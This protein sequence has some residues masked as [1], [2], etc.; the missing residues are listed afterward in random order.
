MTTSLIKFHKFT[1]L[2]INVLTTSQDIDNKIKRNLTNIVS[3]SFLAN[4][5]STLMT[6]TL[7]LTLEKSATT[8]IVY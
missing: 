6:D 7:P 3:C 4:S 2:N 5:A 8:K 1:F